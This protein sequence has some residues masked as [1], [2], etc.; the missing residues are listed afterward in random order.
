MALC[1]D[2]CWNKID[3]MGFQCCIKLN[4]S[5]SSHGF[6]NCGDLKKKKYNDIYT[7]KLKGSDSS[8]RGLWVKVKVA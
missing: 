2:K 7:D 5:V 6:R 8:A 3:G 1:A 4:T